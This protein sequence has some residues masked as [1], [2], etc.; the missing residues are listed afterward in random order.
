MT[1]LYPE[2]TGERTYHV[3]GWRD[4]WADVVTLNQHFNT[5]VVFWA[6]PGETT[7]LLPEHGE[8]LKQLPAE[9]RRRFPAA[10]ESRLR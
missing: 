1:G 2:F 6:D 9:L 5:I 8:R 10:R 7:N 4:R 3:S